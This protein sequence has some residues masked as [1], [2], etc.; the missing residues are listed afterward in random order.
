MFVA[1]NA[2]DAA[3]DHLRAGC[4]AQD[5][6]Q[7]GYRK[8]APFTAVGLH[9]LHGLVLAARGDLTA[10]R[11]ALTRELTFVSTVIQ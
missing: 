4:A 7:A 8:R 1:R 3:L 5:A 9:L 6:Q 2:F 10:A 11:G